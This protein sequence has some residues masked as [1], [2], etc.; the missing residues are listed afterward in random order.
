[1]KHFE[2][3]EDIFNMLSNIDDPLWADVILDANNDK[4]PKIYPVIAKQYS[5]D[6]QVITCPFVTY[7]RTSFRP[8]SNKDYTEEAVYMDIT[9]VTT[10]YNE[11]VSLANI[12]ADALDRHSTDLID[13][14]Q[15]TNTREDYIADAYVQVISIEVS[16]K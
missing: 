10:T 12:A 13:Y 3:G 4:I 14:I 7:R 1:M 6:E 8:Y 11:S 9:I 15:I 16:L 5:Y 2:V